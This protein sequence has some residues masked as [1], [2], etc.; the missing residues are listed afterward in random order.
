MGFNFHRYFSF[1][2][3]NVRVHHSLYEITVFRPF[4]KILY[5]ATSN[6]LANDVVNFSK[7]FLTKTIFRGNSAWLIYKNA[8]LALSS[9]KN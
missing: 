7:C 1:K 2:L 8:E 4:R 3:K 9:H 5:H 6:S